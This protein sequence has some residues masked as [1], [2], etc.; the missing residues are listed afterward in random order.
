MTTTLDLESVLF[1]RAA[2][3]D[4]AALRKSYFD[5]DEFL[6]VDDFLPPEVMEQWTRA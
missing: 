6:V 1:K 3:L 2:E 5:Q 4:A